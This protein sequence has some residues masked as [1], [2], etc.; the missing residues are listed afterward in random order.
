MTKVIVFDKPN[1]DHHVFVIDLFAPPRDESG[2]NLRD[3]TVD[4]EV[5]FSSRKLRWIDQLDEV[6]DWWPWP[7]A[8]VQ[9]N[10]K[11]PGSKSFRWVAMNMP[12]GFAKLMQ[13]LPE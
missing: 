12:A 4:G 11:P 13:T 2:F 8:V 1:E 5:C 7:A 6:P 10:A 9:T 3:I